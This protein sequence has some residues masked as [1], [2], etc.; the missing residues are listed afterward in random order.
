MT[1]DDVKDDA[2]VDAETKV[3]G[4]RVAAG[5][6]AERIAR[7]FVWCRRWLGFFF[8]VVVALV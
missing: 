7:D 3:L 8:Q 2:A 5:G 6:A 4:C 1:K